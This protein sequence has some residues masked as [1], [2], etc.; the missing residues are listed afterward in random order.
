MTISGPTNGL[1]ALVARYPAILSDVW[2][3]VHN[4]VEPH[5]SAVE[6]LVKYREEGGRVVL[7]TNAPRPGP[8]IVAQLDA[9]DIPRTAYDD[10]ISSGDATRTLLESWRGRTIARVGPA[11]DDVLFEGLDLTFGGDR[12]ATAVVVTDLDTDDDTPDDY[13]DRMAIWR[14]RNLPLICAN[15]D[16][17]VEDG[18]RIVYCGGA[19]ADAYEDIGGRVMMA[20]KPYSPIYEQAKA[21]LD[22]AASHHFEKRDIIAIGDSIRTDSIGAA[23]FG[24][25]LLFITGSIHAAELDAFNN[26]PAKRVADFVSVS[27]ANMVGFM[28]RLVW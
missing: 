18:D 16:K 2:G 11:V 7:I 21:M 26:P 24:I 12:E 8:S 5:W 28:P 20:G 1:S 19:L 3:V 13:N 22:A 9:M 14:E 10:L 4:G 27:R 23:Q 25:D 6:A 17:V 15:P